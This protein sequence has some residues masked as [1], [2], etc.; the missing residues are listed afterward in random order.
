MLSVSKVELLARELVEQYK[1]LSQLNIL[2][3]NIDTYYQPIYNK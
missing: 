3:E 1:V 2:P